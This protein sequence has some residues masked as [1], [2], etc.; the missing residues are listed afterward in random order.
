MTLIWNIIQSVITI[1]EIR[2]CVWMMEKFAEPRYS[3]KK[4]KIVEWIVT[5]GVGG[6]YAYN[7]WVASYFSRVIILAV[8]IALS[9]ATVWMFT[10]YRR[11]AILLTANYLL[12]SGLIDLALMS[13]AELIFQR[14]GMFLHIEYV[15]DGFRMGIICLS[16]SL[17]FIICWMTRARVN[18]QVLLQLSKKKISSICILLCVVEYVGVH[19]LTA[20][21]GADPPITYDFLIRLMFCLIVIFLLLAIVGIIVLY[22]EKKDQL[23]AKAI[24]LNSLDHENQRMIKLY[25]ERE[26][27]YHDFKNHLLVLDGFAQ[28]GNLEQ[29]R[30]YMEQIREPFIQKPIKWRTGHS[31]LDLILNYKFREAENQQIKVSCVVYG[32]MDFAT[33]ISSEDACSLMG[34]LWDNAIEACN[35]LREKEPWIDFQMH[36]RPEKFLIEISNPYQEICT[37]SNGKFKTMKSERQFHGI[38]LR[39]IQEITE[40]YRGYYNCV[41][42]DHIFKVEVMIC[43]NKN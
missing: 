31:I 10:Y 34:N 22:Y 14:R 17:L 32:Y 19:I 41:V 23:K 35:R 6:L 13:V 24:Y 21:L 30:A 2:V 9:L 8:L 29:Y 5:L 43:N 7:R 11:M 3:G 20:I 15:N 1:L 25:R 16:K 37:D 36:I 33:E 4:Q 40:R 42:Y 12:I 39:T 18:K 28:D 26:K 38:G 27:M